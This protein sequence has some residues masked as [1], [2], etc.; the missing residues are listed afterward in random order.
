M[1]VVSILSSLRI[2]VLSFRLVAMR[3]VSETRC[4]SATST[5]ILIALRSIATE[6]I[7]LHTLV[8]SRPAKG[9]WLR[10]YEEIH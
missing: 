1:R 8:A 9:A 6:V 10:T 2:C 5:S 7:V 4:F 3:V